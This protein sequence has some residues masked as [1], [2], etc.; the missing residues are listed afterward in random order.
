M[1]QILVIYNRLGI[2]KAWGLCIFVGGATFAN[3]IWVSISKV[4]GSSSVGDH[5]CSSQEALGSVVSCW[6]AWNYLG[7]SENFQ[8]RGNTSHWGKSKFDS[9]NWQSSLL[10]LPLCLPFWTLIDCT[11]EGNVYSPMPS[12]G[13]PLVCTR[14]Y[15]FCSSLYGPASLIFPF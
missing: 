2:M 1:L 7:C 5:L 14:I 11:N 6:G 13:S 3:H 12:S 10:S 9:S 4:I 8:W 15:F